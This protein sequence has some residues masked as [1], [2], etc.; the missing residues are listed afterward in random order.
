MQ[1]VAAKRQANRR[2]KRVAPIPATS[3]L[4]A[5]ITEVSIE[6][7]ITGSSTLMITLS[8]ADWLVL[9]SACSTSTRTGASTYWT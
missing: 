2:R 6:D 9:D 4:A 8:D 7:T 5:A 1:L 3:D